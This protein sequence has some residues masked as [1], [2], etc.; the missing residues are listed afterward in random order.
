MADEVIATA[1]DSGAASAAPVEQVTQKVEANDKPPSLRETLIAA[2]KEVTAKNEAKAPV[3]ETVSSDAPAQ[4]T[5]APA[6]KPAQEEFTAPQSWSAP[7]KAKWA[8][9]DPILR[10]EIVKR[11]KD[12]MVGSEKLTTEHKTIK[13]QWDE[14]EQVLT[15]YKDTFAQRGVKATQVIGNLLAAAQRA[16]QDPAGFIKSLAASRGLDLATLIDRPS[17][18]KDTGPLDPDL[19]SIRAELD[20]FKSQ[21]KQQQSLA[22]QQRWQAAVSQFEAFKGEKDAAGNPKFPHAEKVRVEMGLK[23]GRNPNLTLAEAYESALWDHPD[24]RQERLAAEWEKRE[25]ERVAN[26]KKA[27]AASKSVTGSVPTNVVAPDFDPKNLRAVLKAG[28]QQSQG[29]AR[30]Q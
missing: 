27:E 12:M 1:V 28:Y 26:L 18:T 30:I 22:E 17:A 11:E 24:T 8:A 29:S 13:S 15:P 14:I 4:V 6:A 2:H 9:L 25:A 19:A 10:N 5:P 20:A 23:I 7:A 16:E 3:A 21:Q